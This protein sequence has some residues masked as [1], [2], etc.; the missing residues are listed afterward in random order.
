VFYNYLTYEQRDVQ[1]ILP[2]RE[3]FAGAFVNVR[4]PLLDPGVL[5]VVTNVPARLRHGKAL[6]RRVLADL[7]PGLDG[8]PPATHEGYH[9]NYAVEMATHAHQLDEWSRTSQS[10]LDEVIPLEFGQQL[11]REST[12]RRPLRRALRRVQRRGRRALGVAEPEYAQVLAP[13]KA[14][15]RWAILRMALSTD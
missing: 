11:I 2:W 15:Q 8:I 1:V 4:N 13:H 3:R 12:R 9:P 6:F 10:R 5:D 7:S 14:L